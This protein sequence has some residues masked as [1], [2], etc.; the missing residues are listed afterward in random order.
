M[1]R[2]GILT[3]LCPYGLNAFGGVFPASENA[4]YAFL[5]QDVFLSGARGTLVIAIFPFGAGRLLRWL[6]AVC[7]NSQLAQFI[8]CE[9]AF[10]DELMPDVGIEFAVPAVGQ[11]TFSG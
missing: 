10:C 9:H 1:G 4:C 2:E 7:P 5:M 11:Q 8:V 3:L 6:Q